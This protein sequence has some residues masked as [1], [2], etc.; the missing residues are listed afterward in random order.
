MLTFVFLG[1]PHSLGTLIEWKL[2]R[3]GYEVIDPSSPHSLGTLIE[4]KH[5][6]AFRLLSGSSMSP[7]AGDIN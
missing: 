6:T 1:S 4:W 5:N 2:T 3:E 7:L